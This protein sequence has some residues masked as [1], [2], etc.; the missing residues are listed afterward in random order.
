MTIIIFGAVAF[1][2]YYSVRIYFFFRFS[3][4][5]YVDA[6]SDW[7]LVVGVVIL[8]LILIEI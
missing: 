5:L 1:R 3:W 6:I 8:E 7:V 4:K 2:Y